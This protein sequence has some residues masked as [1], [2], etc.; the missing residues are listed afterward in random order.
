M[1]EGTFRFSSATDGK[2]EILFRY[3]GSSSVICQ[4]GQKRKQRNLQGRPIYANILKLK[5]GAQ[6]G[7]SNSR[8]CTP[9]IILIKVQYFRYKT[10]RVLNSQR[11]CENQTSVSNFYSNYFNG[12]CQSWVNKKVAHPTMVPACV[13]QRDFVLNVPFSRTYNFSYISKMHYFSRLGAPCDDAFIF[14]ICKNIHYMQVCTTVLES[15]T[16]LDFLKVNIL[17]TYMHIQFNLYTYSK[18]F[19]SL[20]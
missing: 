6:A 4:V 2:R 17:H 10:H 5:L 12:T 3:I 18:F 7:T 20:L 11:M 15:Q 1:H 8:Q 19:L 13:F 9:S 14:G 16:S